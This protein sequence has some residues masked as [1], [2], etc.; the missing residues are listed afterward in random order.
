MKG[1]LTLQQLLAGAACGGYRRTRKAM[2]IVQSGTNQDGISA[3]YVKNTIWS[4]MRQE[5]GLIMDRRYFD[6]IEKCEECVILAN[7][8]ARNA[9]FDKDIESY[10]TSRL[11]DLCTMVGEVRTQLM[12][13]VHSQTSKEPWDREI[14]ISK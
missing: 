1:Q 9:N 4:R 11:Q 3:W 13:E 5:R 6:L 12:Y 14:D 7:A 8:M 2:A 10:S